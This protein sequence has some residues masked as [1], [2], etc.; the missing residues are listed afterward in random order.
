MKHKIVST[1]R[2]PTVHV[3]VHCLHSTLSI[4]NLKRLTISISSMFVCLFLKL[5][6]LF[7]FSFSHC[8]KIKCAPLKLVNVSSVSNW[9]KEHIEWIVASLQSRCERESDHISIFSIN[10]L[11]YIRSFSVCGWVCV[12]A[13]FVIF[14]ALFYIHLNSVFYLSVNKNACVPFQTICFWFYFTWW[15]IVWKNPLD[16]H[17]TQK[18]NKCIW[19]KCF[20]CL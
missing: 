2:A 18:I 16:E 9:N 14:S 11:S 6:F 10:L 15:R 5:I 4:H 12:C 19:T 3:F 7:C 17:L 8:R 20:Q 1:H 13:C